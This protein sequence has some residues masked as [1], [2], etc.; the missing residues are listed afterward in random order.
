MRPFHLMPETLKDSVNEATMIL[1]SCQHHRSSLSRASSLCVCACVRVCA[2]ACVRACVCVLFVFC[3][4]MCVWVCMGCTY[5]I[6]LFVYMGC[7]HLYNYVMTF[8]TLQQ[9][10]FP[11]HPQTRPAPTNRPNSAAAQ[12][13]LWVSLQCLCRIPALAPSATHTHTTLHPRP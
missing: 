10:F 13:I 2:R 9:Y 8:S 11:T 12:A 3:V 4:C 7:T 5:T 6:I 1:S